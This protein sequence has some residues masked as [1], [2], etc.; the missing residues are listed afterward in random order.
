M[1]L[2][3]IDTGKIRA[4]FPALS[5]EIRPGVPLVYLDTTAT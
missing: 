2:G 3:D 5:R 1:S 4:E